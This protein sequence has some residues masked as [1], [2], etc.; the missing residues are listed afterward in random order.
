MIFLARSHSRKDM[1]LNI[2]PLKLSR[3]LSLKQFLRPYNKSLTAVIAAE[4]YLMHLFE[5][6]NLLAI[7]T[8]RV[9]IVRKLIPFD[10]TSSK[11]INMIKHLNEQQ[12]RS[13]L[14]QITN[15]PKFTS[16]NR[17]LSQTEMG[18]IRQGQLPPLHLRNRRSHH[19]PFRNQSSQVPTI[20]RVRVLR[21]VRF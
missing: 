21:G 19:T 11:P 2:N 14:S 16:Q 12:L 7:H 5:N 8:K 10:S 3:A 17:H 20:L 13:A 1:L 4:A 15:E 18:G 9:I 6:T